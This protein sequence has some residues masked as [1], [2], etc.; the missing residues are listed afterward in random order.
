MLTPRAERERRKPLIFLFM[1]GTKITTL[2]TVVKRFVNF[3]HISKQHILKMNKTLLAVL[4]LIALA[5]VEAAPLNPLESVSG[6]QNA[7]SKMDNTK[8][9]SNSANLPQIISRGDCCYSVCN[10]NSKGNIGAFFSCDD[11]CTNTGSNSCEI[12]SGKGTVTGTP[13]KK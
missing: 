11:N 6:A 10:R 3:E 4:L 5:F 7:A 2:S 12:K 1:R 9:L 8:P 13:A